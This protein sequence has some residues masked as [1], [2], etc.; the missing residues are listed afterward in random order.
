AALLDLPAERILEA[1]EEAMTAGL[2]GEVAGAVDHFMFSHALVRNAIYGRLSRSR[3]VRLHLRVGGALEQA[4]GSGGAAG[5]GELAHHFFLARELGGAAKA[6]R[7]AVQAGDEA[8]R[9]LAYEEA[10]AHYR[11][12]LE[13]F[14]LGDERDEAAR[15]DI[16]LTLGRVQW[17]AGDAAARE[18]YFEAADSAGRRGAARQLAY[19]ALGL[20]ERYW[21]A[22]AVDPQY[23][24]LLARALDELGPEDSKP[25]S[26]VMARMAE[27]LHFTAPEQGVELSLEALDMARRIGGVDT[28]VTA[29]MGRHVALLHIEH[30][31][32][33]LRLID[34]V[35]GLA[36]GHPALAAEAHHWRLF[37]LCELGDLT[38]AHRDHAELTALAHTLRQPL[39]QH[40]AVG[41]EGAFAH[42][43]GDVEA[44][45]RL[46]G[47]SAE[48][49]KQAEVW[50]A[51]SSLASMLF[52]LRRQQGRIYELL[53]AMQSLAGGESATLAWSAALALAEVETGAV[54][55]GRARY[56]KLAGPDFAAIPRDWYWSGTAAVLAETCAALGDVERAPRLYALLE[57]FAERSIQIIFTACWG[58]IHRYLGLLAGVMDRFDVAERHFE[59]ALLANARM[60]ALLMTAETQCAYGALLLR[61]GLPGDAERAADLGLLAHRVSAPRGLDG[62]RARAELLMAARA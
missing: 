22:G 1:M 57:P 17:Q 30:L 36:Q 38:E 5:P 47:R 54:E 32:K 62:L 55:E 14:D 6:V 59:A 51:T 27:N 52:T 11:R 34:E 29:L 16:L 9:S 13:A 4:A 18:T 33:R 20:G 31:D 53:P 43:A 40:L 23:Q 50:H 44:A 35:L 25:R 37:D 48:F 19:A 2:V 39:L 15:C 60:G 12:A 41:W 26:H 42:L 46:A 8:A 61:R 7:Y 28:L 45:E 49:A 56:A 24:Q 58:S 10:A 21:E 3:R